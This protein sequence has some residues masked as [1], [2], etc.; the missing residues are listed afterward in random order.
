MALASDKWSILIILN[1]GYSQVLRFNKIKKYVSGISNKVLSERLK[2]LE[3]DGYLERKMYPEV[4]IRVEYKLTDF[5]Y[6]Y[7][8]KLIE[9][10]EWITQYSDLVIE[11]RKNVEAS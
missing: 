2:T 1:L 11:R 9:L 4:P 5:G 6:S 10:T 7:L 8:Q 3:T